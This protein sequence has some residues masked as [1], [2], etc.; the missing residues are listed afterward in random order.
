VKDAVCDDPH[1][2]HLGG[3]GDIEDESV[4]RLDVSGCCLDDNRI[5]GV[6]EYGQGHAG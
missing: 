4:D 2:T 6:G 5:A 1:L 3:G